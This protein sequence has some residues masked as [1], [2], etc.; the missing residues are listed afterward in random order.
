MERNNLIKKGVVVAVILLFISVSVV[1]STGNRAS[2]DD[3][4]PP[5]TT[6]SFHPP[7]PTG[8][9]GW[10]ADDVEIILEATDDMSGVNVTYYRLNG[11][12]WKTYVEPFT[13]ESDDNYVIEYY[14]VDN[15]SNVEDVK[16]A[17]FKIDQTPPTIDLTW[18]ADKEDGIWYITF[19]A[20]CSDATSGMDRVEFYMDDELVCTDNEAPY[21]WIYRLPITSSVIG[22]IFNPQ[23]SEE[24]VTFFALI[25]IIIDSTDPSDFVSKHFYAI[26]YDE[27]GNSAKGEIYGPCYI[28]SGVYMFQQ[29]TFPNNYEGYIGSFFI[30]ATFDYE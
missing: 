3:I 13:I 11:G 2:F 6:I 19:T 4:T 16:S 25:V 27:A 18:E 26:A 7:T 23:F 12:E 9:N 10:Y 22:L 29:L 15:A 30:R 17:E 5:V 20:F 21:E 24:N 28:P 14:S 8:K 1:P